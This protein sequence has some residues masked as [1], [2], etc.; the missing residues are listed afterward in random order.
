MSK[1]GVIVRAKSIDRTR[2]WT[3]VVR[4]FLATL[5]GVL[6][7]LPT[8]QWLTQTFGTSR[9]GCILHPFFSILVLVALT[10]MFVRFVHR[11]IPDKGD[12]PWLKNIAEVLKDNEH[13]VAD[14]D[15]YNTG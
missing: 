14:V 8:L 6:F 13:K 9:I 2:H 15:G 5:S 11:D 4:F 10:F 7:L 1:P 3:V 12:I